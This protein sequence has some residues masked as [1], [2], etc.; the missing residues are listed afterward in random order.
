MRSQGGG[1]QL[2]WAV[3][4]CAL[5]S[6]P[7]SQKGADD[8]ICGGEAKAGWET[9]AGPGSGGQVLDPDP[10]GP[11]RCLPRRAAGGGGRRRRR[12]EC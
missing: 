1:Q 12:G 8:Q 3:P 11:G 7:H 9:D 4:L 10:A 2:A 6:P 5:V